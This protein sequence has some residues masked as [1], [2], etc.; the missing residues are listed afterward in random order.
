MLIATGIGMYALA[1]TAALSD[2]TTTSSGRWSDFINFINAQFGKEGLIVMWLL[3]GSI[4]ICMAIRK[5]K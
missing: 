4:V 3:L 5:S 2:K 1:L